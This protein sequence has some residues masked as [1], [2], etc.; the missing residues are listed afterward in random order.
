MTL[1]LHHVSPSALLAVYLFI[2]VVATPL[3]REEQHD[4]GC[5]LERLGT[6]MC[7]DEEQPALLYISLGILYLS[8]APSPALLYM[9][10]L[11]LNEHH[12]SF[13]CFHLVL[14]QLLIL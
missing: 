6:L 5:A 4:I 3:L 9:H 14:L 7:R 2:A 1:V 8:L 12:C 10:A 13:C 11:W